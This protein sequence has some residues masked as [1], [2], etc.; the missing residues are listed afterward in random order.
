MDNAQNILVASLTVIA[1]WL[2]FAWPVVNRK[3][4]KFGV[5]VA[6]GFSLYAVYI[7]VTR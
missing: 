2:P 1:V 4:A 3:V 6:L 7:I 5:L